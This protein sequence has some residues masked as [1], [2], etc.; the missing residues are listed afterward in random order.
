MGVTVRHMCSLSIQIG[1]YKGVK[2]LSPGKTI[3]LIT[4]L[5]ITPILGLIIS[6]LSV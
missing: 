5:I 6:V 3:R 4:T 1:E 2:Q